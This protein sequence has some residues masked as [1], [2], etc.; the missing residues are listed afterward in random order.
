LQVKN[1]ASFHGV[2]LSDGTLTF[3][4]GSSV[5]F[6]NAAITG[7]GSGGMTMAGDVDMN[8]YD[9]LNIINA[10]VQGYIYNSADTTIKLDDTI[11]H[12]TGGLRVDGN[13]W[14]GTSSFNINDDLVVTGMSD[15]RDDIKNTT[16]NVH[17]DD[18]LIVYDTTTI[19]GTLYTEHVYPI[20]DDS[21]NIGDGSW[22]Y[23]SMY[24]QW[25]LQ[26]GNYN[27]GDYVS[28][29]SNGITSHGAS[30][31][32]LRSDNN[33]V[34]IVPAGDVYLHPGSNNTYSYNLLPNTDA[35]YNLG[36]IAT[37]RLWNNGYFYNLFAETSLDV[38]EGTFIA[39]SSGINV[40]A[41]QFT[42]DITGNVLVTGYLNVRGDLSDDLGPLTINDTLVQSGS[43]NQVTFNGN[44][45]AQNGLDVTIADLTVG[46]TNFT[47]AQGTGNVTTA[48]DI[49][50]NGGDISSTGTLNLTA[51]TAST[52]QIIDDNQAL[53]IDLADEG[54]TSLRLENSNPSQQADLSVEGTITSGASILIDGVSATRLISSDD[55][56]T[57]QTSAAN[58]DIALDANGSGVINF[59][60]NANAAAGLDVT[61]ADLT[62]G[63]T[64]FTVDDAT[65]NTFVQGT[66]RSIGMAILDGGIDMLASTFQVDTSGNV[67]A[68]G[69]LDVRG[70]LYDLI[71]D[72]TINDNLIVTGTSDLQGAVSNST[73]NL[74]LNDK[75]DIADDLGVAGHVI[76]TGN[77][78]VE[79]PYLSTPNYLNGTDGGLRIGEDNKTGWLKIKDLG[80]DVLE[81]GRSAV[82]DTAELG[83]QINE[84]TGGNFRA[85][86]GY[87]T[88]FSGW[89]VGVGNLLVGD[90]ALLTYK[91][92]D[93]ERI[94][95][96]TGGVPK[97]TVDKDG[98]V[99]SV[100]SVDFSGATELVV[101]NVASAYV[102]GTT[103]CS[104]KGAIVIDSNNRFFGCDGALWQALDN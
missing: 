21:Y 13:V 16:G 77:H 29:A 56:L 83:M 99:V 94:A 101:P 96:L 1:N 59:N 72:L 81:M 67:R 42:V 32:V 43:G 2:M 49:A 90:G 74:N 73:G 95:V 47:V 20:L 11:I 10:D 97:F 61:N 89:A 64:R 78:R 58:G 53:T 33:Y 38:N 71:T 66:L 9:V 104:T 68:L 44:I 100:G 24:A 75:V 102:D 37:S 12:V 26:A 79:A 36:S 28:Y 40:N 45:D 57:I 23:N 46:G 86:I 55:D 63:G 62:V 98:D 91:D 69:N 34:S 84:R 22:R 80:V 4:T 85:G 14:N 87:S 65:G 6:A 60:D 103:V 39:N 93:N 5:D 54:T 76:V 41:G 35:A 7:F 88:D 15:L 17:I 92:T 82:S 50:V 8:G 18:V 48:G 19:N 25:A 3:G 70:N 31:T 27:A 30:A 52:I 51:A